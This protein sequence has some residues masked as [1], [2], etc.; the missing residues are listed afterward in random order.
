MHPLSEK[1]LLHKTGDELRHMLR[2][3]GISCGAKASYSELK[4]LLMKNKVEKSL[5]RIKAMNRASRVLL[6]ATAPV[7]V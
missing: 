3:R 2:T 4:Q 1:D 7:D 6:N 5:A